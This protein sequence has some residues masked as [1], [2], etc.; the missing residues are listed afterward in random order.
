MCVEP[1]LTEHAFKRT[2][3]VW[4]FSE[5]ILVQNMWLLMFLSTC[6]SPCNTRGSASVRF[7]DISIGEQLFSYCVSQCGMVT[8]RRLFKPFWDINSGKCPDNWFL[9]SLRTLPFTYK[10]L[11]RIF[12]RLNLLTT[13]G[14]SVIWIEH[15]AGRTIHI[16]SSCLCGAGISPYYQ[17]FFLCWLLLQRLLH[18]TS[19]SFGDI[20]IVFFIYTSTLCRCVFSHGLIWTF[21]NF[22]RISFVQSANYTLRLKQNIYSTA[23][24]MLASSNLLSKSHR[25]SAHQTWYCLDI[26]SLKSSV[27]MKDALLVFCVL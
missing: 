24:W 23:V 6:F 10:Q 14:K 16:N 27:A 12:S 18:V 11:S 25:K 3:G 2:K 15:G 17:K 13:T 26:S 20:C 5:K 4:C 9:Y 21:Y 22:R 7:A 19:F 1:V 8:F